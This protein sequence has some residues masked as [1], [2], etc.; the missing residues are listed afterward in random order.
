[1]STEAAQC[2]DQ[3]VESYYRAWFRFHPEAAV[4]A[5]VAGF[6]HLLRP[7]HDDEIG[8]LIALDEKLLAGL[9]EIDPASLDEDR[10][11]DYSVLQGATQIEHHELLEFD[12]RRRDP[13]AFLPTHAIYQLTVRPVRDLPAAM[14]SRLARVPD[15]LRGARAQLKTLPEL[16]PVP[17]L[18]A[19]VAEA[20]AGATFL[21]RVDRHPQLSDAGS[22]SDLRRLQD[23]AARAMLDFAKFL[24]DEI[25]PRAA[26]EFA[27]GDVHFER[28]LRYR[29][30]LPVDASQLSRFGER[31]FTE[32]EEQLKAVTLHL[33]GDTDVAALTASIRAEHPTESSLLDVYRDEMRAA[34]RFLAQ[35][36]I[37]SLPAE[38]QLSVVATPE[39]LRHQIPFAAYL[40]PAPND[41]SQQG[42]YYV[43][44]ANSEVLLGEHNYA[45]IQ[46]TC[47][48]EAWPGHHLQFVTANRNPASCS[49][50]RLLNPSA[51]LYEG[52]ALYCEQLMQ[53][54]GFLSRPEQ[55]FILLRDRLW[56]ALRVMLDVDIQVRG[57]SLDQA[58]ERMSEALGFPHQQAMAD[59]TWYCH[60]PAAP[61]G[62]ATGWA[63]INQLRRR[64][65]ANDDDFDLRIFHDRLL[66]AGSVALPLVIQRQFGAAAWE[67]IRTVVELQNTA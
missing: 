53:E 50:P 21:Q 15:H 66:G 2:F 58:A 60:S 5:G 34:H 22:K 20:E 3:L 27:V 6:E 23:A 8:A 9:E 44:P 31:L 56:R 42:Y 26:G 40:D 54:E 59:L 46:H 30:F 62:Y 37:V 35:H 39:F 12:W 36:D 18:E 47:V 67:Q 11:L 57:V 61:M 14:K 19:A 1:M 17:W 43:T 24:Q 13:G 28:L 10:A 32:T 65:I 51:T 29:H 64:A 48:H 52:W 4:D 16:V 38:E 7:Y 25:S 45:G 33:R 41:S 49:L 55:R 63:L